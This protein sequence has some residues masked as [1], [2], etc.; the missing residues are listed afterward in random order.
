MTDTINIDIDGQSFE[1]EKGEMLIEVADRNGDPHSSFLLSQE[2][3]GGGQLPHVSG[4]GGA[5]AEAAAS[6]CHTR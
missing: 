3:H 4:G 5:R 1:A 2:A 6:L